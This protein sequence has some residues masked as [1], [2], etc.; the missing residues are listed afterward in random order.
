MDTPASTLIGSMERELEKKINLPGWLHVPVVWHMIQA[1]PSSGWDTVGPYR[2]C[3]AGRWSLTALPAPER[4][5]WK[6]V[7]LTGVR[8]G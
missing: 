8:H 2:L 7:F 4:Q 3:G 5:E 6:L 1:R